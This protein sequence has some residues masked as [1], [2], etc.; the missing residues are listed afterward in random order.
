MTQI[1]SYSSL[2]GQR[3]KSGYLLHQ[4]AAHLLHETA[5]SLLMTSEKTMTLRDGKR[6]TPEAVKP[7]LGHDN[8]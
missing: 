1:P 2:G 8:I 7:A 6:D 3:I 4:V 5:N